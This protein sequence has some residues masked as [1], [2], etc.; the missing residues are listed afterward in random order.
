MYPNGLLPP[1]YLVC[2]EL[3]DRSTMTTPSPTSCLELPPPSASSP[4]TVREGGS[5]MTA[6]SQTTSLLFTPV[7]GPSHIT[8]ISPSWVNVSDVDVH[9][10]EAQYPLETF[11]R[12]LPEYLKIRS[13]CPAPDCRTGLN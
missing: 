5:T 13:S 7:S 11:G 8:M 9:C 10:I 2:K 3:G 6:N 1:T 12:Q 4:I